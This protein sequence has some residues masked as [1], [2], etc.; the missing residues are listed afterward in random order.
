LAAV[1]FKASILFILLAVFL[2]HKAD[3]HFGCAHSALP[4]YSKYN[5]FGKSAKQKNTLTKIQTLNTPCTLDNLLSCNDEEDNVVDFVFEKIYYPFLLQ[6]KI[7]NSPSIVTDIVSS[8]EQYTAKK[9]I[10][11]KTFLI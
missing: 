3:K 6:D 8:A 9:Y 10:R 2:I 11:F 4:T 5:I 7:N 1:K